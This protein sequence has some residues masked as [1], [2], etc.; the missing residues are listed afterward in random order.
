MLYTIYI[1]YSDI[2]IYCTSYMSSSLST[3]F[4]F[5]LSDFQGPPHLIQHCNMLALVLHPQTH[6]INYEEEW[7]PPACQHGLLLQLGMGHSGHEGQPYYGSPAG[8]GS[9]GPLIDPSPAEQIAALDV[10]LFPSPWSSG[11]CK[12]PDRFSD[13]SSNQTACMADEHQGHE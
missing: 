4:F 3:I 5:S 8:S 10:T 2:D 6:V 9:S 12:D 7:L 1:L 11:S 13:G